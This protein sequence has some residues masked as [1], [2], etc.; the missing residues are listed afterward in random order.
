M[1]RSHLE[2]GLALLLQVALIAAMPLR[3][4]DEA[5]DGA[6]IWLTVR[7]Y[8]RL[9]VMQGDYFKLHYEIADAQPGPSRRSLEKRPT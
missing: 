5:T 1:N 4:A 3:R 9:D 6:A 2:F 8:D 7:A